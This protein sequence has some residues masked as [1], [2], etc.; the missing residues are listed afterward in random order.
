MNF[1][2]TAPSLEECLGHAAFAADELAKTGTR[3]V[4]RSMR[5]L[6]SLV[7]VILVPDETVVI[8]ICGK[9]SKLQRA[10]HRN[11]ASAH[12]SPGGCVLRC[13]RCDVFDA[14]S[15]ATRNIG[16][17]QETSPI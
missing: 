6:R 17:G 2:N 15:C 8:A 11:A 5:L 9:C 3:D 14:L 7:S 4:I 1:P 16:S 12:E 10:R 13:M